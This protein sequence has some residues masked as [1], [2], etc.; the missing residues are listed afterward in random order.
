MEH[1]NPQETSDLS[2]INKQQLS[3]YHI[4]DVFFLVLRNWYWILLCAIV[5]TLLAYLIAHGQTRIYESNAKILIRTGSGLSINDND[6][7]EGSI[8]NA[9]GIASFYASSI[10]N[11]IMI[12][13]SK[14]T[15]QKA[16]EDLQ[17][18]VNYTSKPRFARRA[19][20][21]YGISPVVVEFADNNPQTEGSFSVQII[22]STA[23]IVVE[24]TYSPLISLLV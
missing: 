12:L 11:E 4:K 17:L 6:S 13:T 14:T 5:G 7:R 21:L 8:R 22:D 23:T 1:D 24:C 16:V 18:N 3:N 2:F 10:N 15:V 20:D 9:L 19:K